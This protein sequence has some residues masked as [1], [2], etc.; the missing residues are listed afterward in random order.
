MYDWNNVPSFHSWQ[1]SV[2]SSWR[3]TCPGSWVRWVS[4]IRIWRQLHPDWSTVQYQVRLSCWTHDIFI[5]NRTLFT[6]SMNPQ[7]GK[8]LG[9]GSPWHTGARNWDVNP[10]LLVRTRKEQNSPTNM[11]RVNS[12]VNSRHGL[13]HSKPVGHLCAFVLVEQPTV[14]SRSSPQ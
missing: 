7:K 13:T 9:V 14:R 3:T 4:A 12:R 8:Q 5:V 6:G 11:A 1:R 2:M 10:A